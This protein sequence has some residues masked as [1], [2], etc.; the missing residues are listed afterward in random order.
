MAN[1]VMANKPKDDIAD[2]LVEGD[3]YEQAALSV[4]RMVPL[5][6]DT[7][8]RIA[9]GSLALS[10][11]LA[12]AVLVRR[13]LVQ[14]LEGTSSLSLTLGLLGLNGIV[15]TALCG[16]LPVRQREIVNRGSLSA[17]RA[18]R[19]VR[20]EDFLG[21]FVLLGAGFVAAPV[22]LAVAG[23]LSPSTIETL[24]AYDVRIYRPHETL[25]IDLRIVSAVGGA[26][27]VT[28]LAL[29]QLAR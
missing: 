7:K 11:G 26:L 8:V 24:Y 16:F 6:L 14:S 13:D 23:A 3:T 27:A 21:L 15:T 20:V 22:A 17:Q 28:L 2:T 4:E 10:V 29:R 19:L 12:P 1:T 5:S 25:G 9:I 18:R